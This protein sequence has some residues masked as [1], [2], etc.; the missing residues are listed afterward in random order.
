MAFHRGRIFVVS[1]T[2]KLF[3]CEFVGRDSCLKTVIKERPAGAMDYHNHHLLTSA[4]KQK[5]LMVRWTIPRHT[6]RFKEIRHAIDLQVFEADLEK[7][8]WSSPVKDLGN[9]VLFVGRTGSRA[10]VAVGS[11]D[12]RFHGNRVFLLGYELASSRCHAANVQWIPDCE[13]Y[14]IHTPSYCVYDMINDKASP[15]YLRRGRSRV[16]YSMSAWFF[17][18][19]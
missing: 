14:H 2:E 5:L 13:Q 9:Q 10:L 3:E 8:E 6:G 1:S 15:V 19:Q 12:R 7:G 17:P 18:S 4:D 11:A 16:K